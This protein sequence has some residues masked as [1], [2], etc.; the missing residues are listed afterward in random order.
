VTNTKEAIYC[1]WMTRSRMQS[2]FR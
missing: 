2:I 1:K